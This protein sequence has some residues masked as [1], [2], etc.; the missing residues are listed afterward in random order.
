VRNGL[1]APQ[2]LAVFGGGS[3][4]GLATARALVGARTRRVVLAGRRPEAMAAAAE[5]LRRRGATLVECVAFDAEDGD[6]HPG[7]VDAV[8]ELLGEVD[9][10]LLAFGVLGDQ[11]RA[12]DDAALAGRIVRTNFA[13]TVSLTI[14]LVR[15][16]RAQGHGTLVALSSVAAERPRRSNFVYGASKAG[17]DAFLQG[18]ADSL[19]GSGVEVIVVRPGFVHSKMTTGLPAAPF[20]TTPE[21][22]AA[23]IVRALVTRPTT[24][25]VP[26]RL[27]WVMSG[28]RHLPRPLFRRLG[29]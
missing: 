3:D 23:A 28:L 14:P 1:G 29:G 12:P 13:G 5:D 17:M 25:W 6:S 18:L 8:V 26:G 22:V 19:E 24:V 16:L 11:E 2:S 20:S 4:I 10:A 21:E 27:R 9:V 15:R 7:V